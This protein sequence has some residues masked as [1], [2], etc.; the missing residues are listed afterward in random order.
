[1]PGIIWTR[2]KVLA[3][4]VMLH[5]AAYAINLTPAQQTG[6]VR[7]KRHKFF[8]FLK[9]PINV[10]LILIVRKVIFFA[11][12][13]HN[14]RFRGGKDFFDPQIVLSAAKG[15]F[16]VSKLDRK[17]WGREILTEEGDGGG[18]PFR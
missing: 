16:G 5:P 7:H 17:D 13:T 1:M 8:Y 18:S 11:A 15:N 3:N 6:T 9:I 12:K 14:R 2:W 4:M 10:P